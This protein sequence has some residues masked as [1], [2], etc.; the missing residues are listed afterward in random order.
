RCF[1]RTLTPQQLKPDRQRRIILVI[2]CVALLLDNMLYMVIVP[3]IPDY[4]ADLESEQ[5][6]HVHVVLHPNSSLNPTDRSAAKKSNLDI[7]IGVLFASKAILQLIVNPIS[8]TF[9]DR[10]Y[11]TLFVA[12]SL[13]GL[14]SAFADTSGLAMIADKYTEEAERTRAL[15]IALAFISFGSLFAGKRVP[16]IVLA[17]VCLIDGFMFLTIIRPSKHDSLEV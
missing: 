14:G 16:F 15:G 10:N 11:A 1:A 17:C 13:Q 5:A 6:E 3:I 8:G 12:R 9:I 7:Q 2:V 4:L